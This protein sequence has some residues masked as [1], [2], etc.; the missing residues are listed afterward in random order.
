[1]IDTM[2]I[3]EQRFI[4]TPLIALGSACHDR[5]VPPPCSRRSVS[6]LCAVPAA[7]PACWVQ[8]S[9]SPAAWVPRRGSP[10][11]WVPGHGSPGAA[12]RGGALPAAGSWPRAPAPSLPF[13]H[14]ADRRW[15]NSAWWRCCPPSPAAAAASPGRPR[16]CV[17]PRSCRA[18]A[19]AWPFGQV[20]R[21]RR[22]V[23]AHAWPRAPR[24]ADRTSAPAGRAVPGRPWSAADS[25]IG[26]ATGPAKPAGPHGRPG[27]PAD[28]APGLRPAG[29]GA[30]PPHPAAAAGRQP[31]PPVAAAGWRS[32][33]PGGQPILPAAVLASP[34]WPS[35]DP[36]ARPRRNPANRRARPPVPEPGRRG[37]CRGHP[38]R[39]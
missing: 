39:C 10:P 17:R 26:R 29:P 6:R 35:A 18:A 23:K 33:S 28:A 22:R 20:A 14:A 21:S 25:A 37:S 9:G 11:G 19:C 27:C 34:R 4:V 16:P 1:M 24:V 8:R 36:R 2:E 31:G 15:P 38:R 30:P 13:V 32:G 12:L 7:M 3:L 5:P